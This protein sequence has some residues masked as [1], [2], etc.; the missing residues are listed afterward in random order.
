MID[1]FAG[2]AELTAKII[3]GRKNRWGWL[4]S[5][6]SGAVWVYI[7]LTSKMYGLLLI[8]VPAFYINAK[9]F[10]QWGKRK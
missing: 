3:I 2:A 9:Y 1:L 8:V 5:S 4:L 6:A 10:I 7:A